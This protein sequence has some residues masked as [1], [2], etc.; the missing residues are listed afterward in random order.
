MS[1]ASED[2]SGSEEPCIELHEEPAEDPRRLAQR[3]PARSETQLRRRLAHWRATN[4]VLAFWHTYLLLI[5]ACAFACAVLVVIL[6]WHVDWYRR[7]RGCTDVMA[8]QLHF[9]A[10][11][12]KSWLLVNLASELLRFCYLLALDSWR[13]DVFEA[14]R[15][16][17]SFASFAEIEAGTLYVCGWPQPIG[18]MR[19]YADAAF[20]VIIF[21][22]MDILPGVTL[23]LDFATWRIHYCLASTVLVLACVHVWLFLMAWMVGSTALKITA[24]RAAWNNRVVRVSRLG[25]A[26]RVLAV[27][28]LTRENTPASTIPGGWQLESTV[29]AEDIP[30]ES[31]SDEESHDEDSCGR[32]AP[33][34]PGNAGHVLVNENLVRRADRLAAVGGDKPLDVCVPVCVAFHNVCSVYPL[35]MSTAATLYGLVAS[36]PAVT[37]I[38]LEAV[39]MVLI[40]YQIG[41][42]VIRPRWSWFK[43][44]SRLRYLEEWGEVYCGLKYMS[45][46]KARAPLCIIVFLMGVLAGSLHWWWSVSCCSLILFVC[47]V[48]QL[49]LLIQKPWSWLC[50]ILE[51]FMLALFCL[52]VLWYNPLLNPWQDGALLGILL[53]PREF[54]LQ[55]RL[56]SGERARY[57]ALFALGSFHLS[58]VCVICN[59]M[60]S[61]RKFATESMFCLEGAPNCVYYPIDYR[62]ALGG[63]WPICQMDFP[64]HGS[65]MLNLADF[66]LMSAFTYEPAQ[67][68][69]GLLTQ[70]FPGWRVA[71]A[72]LPLDVRGAHHDVTTFFEFASADNSTAVFAVR[73]TT[74]FFDALQDMDLWLPVFMMYIFEN[75][76]PNVVKLWGPAIA[77]MCRQVYML[78]DARFTLTFIHLLEMV[79]ARMK[80]HPDRNFYI[81][82]HSLGGGIAKLVA[83]EIQR[84]ELQH[85]GR[86]VE[87]T[88]VAFAAPGIGVAEA[89]LFGEDK[90]STNRY[91]SVTVRPRHDIVSRID[92]NT[93]ATIPVGCHG[94]PRR[95]HSIYA[96][97]CAFYKKCGSLRPDMDL[98]IPCGWCENMP[99]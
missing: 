66:G 97:L 34:Q 57:L 75:L 50:G 73:G 3:P 40:L 21:A 89:L 53:I 65:S 70:Y 68:V 10:T 80:A 91:T 46:L 90:R 5:V 7:Y 22:T 64:I 12:V 83:A 63:R 78:Q 79:Q 49:T 84:E 20:Q 14:Y 31:S 25:T 39:C 74:D 44:N 17:L 81:T 36:K 45:Q 54:G 59:C 42:P 72:H 85:A 18:K 77:W 33:A 38:G 51:S 4:Q 43:S 29:V 55:K 35:L 8:F 93:G 99:C 32:I 88:A 2:S 94:S 47:F 95:C 9:L 67:D 58:L 1:Q 96:T 27:G 52:L 19:K 23:A 76:G 37:V 48:A 82:G 61:E 86:H 24:F 87:L 6:F 92:H 41:R 11:F 28:R 60:A 15:R 62:G 26:T 71:Y 13:E 56:A 16:A 30:S 98:K 69:Q